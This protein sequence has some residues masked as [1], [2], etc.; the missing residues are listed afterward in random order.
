[1]EGPKPLTCRDTTDSYFWLRVFATVRVVLYAYD[2]IFDFTQI[3]IDK[4]GGKSSKKFD[5][6]LLKN[7][8]DFQKVFFLN[9]DLGARVPFAPK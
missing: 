7:N 3:Q 5:I 9:L 6:F 4:T 8:N 2:K 1:M